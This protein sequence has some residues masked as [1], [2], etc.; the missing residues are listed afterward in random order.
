[1]PTIKSLQ[2]KIEY[3]T[4]QVKHHEE[5]A[6]I[7]KGMYESKKD[8]AY[9]YEERMHKHI[10]ELDTLVRTEQRVSRKLRALL[11]RLFEASQRLFGSLPYDLWCDLYEPVKQ[12]RLE[13]KPTEEGFLLV[14]GV[15]KAYFDDMEDRYL[16]RKAKE[17]SAASTT[18]P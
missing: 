12:A 15:Q 2:K 9:A 18:Q 14:R 7:Y 11:K 1:M 16:D 3:L 8:A 6:Q 17:D 13:E 4:S 10:Q 5:Q